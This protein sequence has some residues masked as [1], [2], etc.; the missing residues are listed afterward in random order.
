MKGKGRHSRMPNES[1]GK[2]NHRHKASQSSIGNNSPTNTGASTGLKKSN[3]MRSDVLKP[4]SNKN[5]YPKGL[6]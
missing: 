2:G 1:S 6:A 4:P 5:P 3:E